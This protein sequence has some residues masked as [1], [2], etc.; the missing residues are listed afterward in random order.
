MVLK[1]CPV[2]KSNEFRWIRVDS[3]SG[4]VW[5]SDSIKGCIKCGCVILNEI[6]EKNNG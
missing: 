4:Y 3:P 1:E 5:L 2:C 6:E